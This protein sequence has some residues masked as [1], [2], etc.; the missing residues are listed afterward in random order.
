MGDVL[1]A[2]VGAL[3]GVG[4]ERGERE[5]GMRQGHTKGAPRA[6]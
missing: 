5:A 6:H 4:R 3:D 1:F 2:V